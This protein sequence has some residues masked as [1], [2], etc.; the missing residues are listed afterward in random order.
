MPDL[1]LCWRPGHTHPEP[2][3][4]PAPRTF[5]SR[6]MQPEVVAR[7]LADPWARGEATGRQARPGSW[8]LGARG[9]EGRKGVPLGCSALIPR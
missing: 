2:Q 1:T 9:R 8:A 3:A 4:L 5:C 7:S 6:S